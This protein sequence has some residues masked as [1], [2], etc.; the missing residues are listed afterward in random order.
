MTRVYI[1]MYR[2]QLL[3]PTQR[4]IYIT[5]LFITGI[6]RSSWIGVV[7]W[8]FSNARVTSQSQKGYTEGVL[9]H[10]DISKLGRG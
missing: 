8:A 10:I 3:H 2:P 7:V 5:E 6:E 4:K 1:T 9:N